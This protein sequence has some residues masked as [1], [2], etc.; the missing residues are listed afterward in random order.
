M[1]CYFFLYIHLGMNINIHLGLLTFLLLL[2][3]CIFLASLTFLMGYFPIWI[4]LQSIFSIA[5]LLVQT[6][7]LSVKQLY[8]WSYNVEN[9]WLTIIFFQFHFS[10]SSSFKVII[11]HRAL[12]FIVAIKELA[13]D[14]LILWRK[15][16]FFPVVFLTFYYDV[17]R[18]LF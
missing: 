6:L 4:T 15:S 10:F 12:V 1:R 8:G 2:G 13:A 3:L 9:A 16:F 7:S 5:S 14:L 17:S 18:F 11:T